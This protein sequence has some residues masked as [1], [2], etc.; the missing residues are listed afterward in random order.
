[1][2][3]ILSRGRFI[4]LNQHARGT[5]GK[6]T[7][8]EVTNFLKDLIVARLTDFLGTLNISVLDL[9]AKYDEVSA[10]TRAK[11]AADFANMG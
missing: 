8:E 6:Y 5:Q 4:G 9:P 1:L 11:V 3:S 10:G 7:T 2:A